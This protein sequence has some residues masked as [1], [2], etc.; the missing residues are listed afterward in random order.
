[1]ARQRLALAWLGL[2]ADFRQNALAAAWCFSAAYHYANR[3]ILLA[4][5]CSLHPLSNSTATHSASA[6]RSCTHCS[7]R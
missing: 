3:W 2:L 7:I 1:M 5:I 4:A 6:Q